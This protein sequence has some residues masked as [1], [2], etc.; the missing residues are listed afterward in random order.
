MLTTEARGT[1][2]L[3]AMVGFSYGAFVLGGPG[4]CAIV[5]ATNLLLLA[6]GGSYENKR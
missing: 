4:V 2:V 3:L 1:L 6:V 5:S